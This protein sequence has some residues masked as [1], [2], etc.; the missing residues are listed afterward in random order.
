MF[1]ITDLHN[2]SLCGLDD[3]AASY[4]EMCKMID[5]SYSSGVR[6]ICFTPHY[7]NSDGRDCTPEQIDISFERAKAYCQRY[8][9]DMQLYK[10]S[11]MTYHFDCVDSLAEKKLYTIAGSRYVLTDFLATPDARS[12][13]MGLERLFNCGYVPIIAHIE[14]YPCLYGKIESVRR[15]SEMGAIIQMNSSSLFKGLMSKRR[16]QSLKLLSEGLVDIMASDAHDGEMRTPELK[17]AA[18]FVE[19]RFGYEY[20]EQLFDKN[21]Q[22]IISNKRF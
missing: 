19:A 8:M 12:I 10:G 4:E 20:A 13:I 14:R 15:M 6:T 5:I 16:R 22:K 9:P 3:G 1:N 7:F 11:E 17:R 18:E 21:P 2:H